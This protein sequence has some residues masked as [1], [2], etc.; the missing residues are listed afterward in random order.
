MVTKTSTSGSFK[1]TLTYCL[2]ESK[3]AEIVL[4]EGI[5]TDKLNHMVSDFVSQTDLNKRITKTV[6]HASISFSQ[7]DLPRLTKEGEKEILNKY[8]ETLGEKKGI[9]FNNTQ[10]LIVRHNDKDHPHYHLVA[11]VVDNDGKRLKLDHIG[12]KMK[13]ISKQ[14]TKEFKLTPAVDKEL[15]QAVKEAGYDIKKA[16]K[17][18]I[19]VEKNGRKEELQPKKKHERDSGLSF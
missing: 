2:K 9:D 8:L 14:I 4:S 15:Q 19:E 3:D 17:N 7:E 16:L 11:N 12:L 5:R 13:D 10:F 18:Q 6:F 1:G